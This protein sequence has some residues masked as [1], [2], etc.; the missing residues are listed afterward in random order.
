MM[1]AGGFMPNRVRATLVAGALAILAG[2]GSL[3]GSQPQERTS[4]DVMRG[5]ELYR[6]HC[7]ACH[8]AQVHWRD[9]RLV[10]SW[11]DL[12][13][14]VARWQRM[15]GQSWSREE[16]EDVAA[17]LNRVFYELP[18]PL[19]GCGGSKASVPG[20]AAARDR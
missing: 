15:G 19:P 11:D 13:Y 2:C 8:T 18:C 14:Q 3:L 10:R 9:A 1:V 20:P 12:R 7:S 17:Y 6:L 4:T 5:S 16:V